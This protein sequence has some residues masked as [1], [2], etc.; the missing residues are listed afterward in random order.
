M[1]HCCAMGSVIRR[2]LFVAVVAAGAAAL[3]GAG[4]ALDGRFAGSLLPVARA[5]QVAGATGLLPAAPAPLPRDSAKPA[6]AAP[7]PAPAL[8]ALPA[9]G[10]AA[11]ASLP[12]QAK[13]ALPV[14]G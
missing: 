6:A 2:A 7:A 8:P 5:D 13:E 14:P 9:G 1:D 3:L 11:P 10:A 12:A 4:G